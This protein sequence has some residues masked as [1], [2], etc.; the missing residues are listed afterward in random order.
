MSRE[1][2]WQSATP[3]M[4]A[5]LDRSQQASPRWLDSFFRPARTSPPGGS[6]AR[7]PA[8]DRAAHRREPRIQEAPRGAQEIR[9]RTRRAQRARIPLSGSAVARERAEEVEADRQG[10]NGADD[11]ASAHD[12]ARLTAEVAPA[13][14]MVP[15]RETPGFRGL[16][17]LSPAG[18]ARMVDVSAKAE[19]VREACARVT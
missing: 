13:R 10:P 17:H 5:Y 14:F 18:D 9:R 19:T 15:S 6:H 16:S 7:H 1:A 2:R 8:S 3:R 11:Q 12:H 4:F